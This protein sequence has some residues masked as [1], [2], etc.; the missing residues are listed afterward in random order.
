MSQKP[1]HATLKPSL[2]LNTAAEIAVALFLLA[3][4]ALPARAQQPTP[5]ALYADY[6]WTNCLRAHGF[7]PSTA[8]FQGFNGTLY[9]YLD[10][11]G[12]SSSVQ[13]DAADPFRAH[14]P[15]T[16]RNFVWD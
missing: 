9:Y 10:E 8:L 7:K 6:W 15:D 16:G 11:T 2:T 12:V 5:D 3:L 13:R 4:S 1:R 14:D